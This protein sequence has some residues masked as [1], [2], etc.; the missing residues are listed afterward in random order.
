MINPEEKNESITVDTNQNADVTQEKNEKE[1]F[2]GE[3]RLDIDIGQEDKNENTASGG[4]KPGLNIKTIIIVALLLLP[5]VYIIYKTMGSKTEQEQV[6]NQAQ[7]IDVAAYENTA[8]ANPNFSN[9]LNLSNAYINSGMAGKAIEPLKKA[10]ELSPNNAAAYSNLGF[11]YT[12]IQQYKEGI[13]YG[14]KAVELDSTFQLAKNNLNWAKSEQKK[15][16]TALE[17][18]E[19]TPEDKKDIAFYTLYGLQF[20]KLQEY[21][22]SI[23]V[24]NKMLTMEPKNAVAL[25]NKGVTYMSMPDYD[26][27]I[28]AFKKAV[29]NNPNDQLAKNNLAWAEGEKK[30]AD[31]MAQKSASEK[32]AKPEKK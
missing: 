28:D 6:V 11:A 24:W 10:I 8:R 2:N 19:K 25:I 26:K 20:L 5:V 9:L 15:L 17:Q 12:I 14:E 7:Q 16:L 29:D 32:I 27:A 18:M 30:K 23:E 22:K 3:E 1:P 4:G 13:A 31:E 21:D